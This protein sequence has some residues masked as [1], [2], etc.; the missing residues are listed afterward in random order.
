MAFDQKFLEGVLALEGEPAAKIQKI[1]S[2]YEADVNGLK[3]NRDALKGEKEAALA[4]VA[5]FEKKAPE[6][7]AK[8]G[9]LEKKVKGAGT[10]EAKAYY[11]AQLKALTDK[12]AADLQKLTVE[13]DEA[14]NRYSSLLGLSEF[15]RAIEGDADKNAPLPISAAKR[16]MLRDLTYTR[17]NFG[18]RII[19][20]KEM[21]LS[22][23]NKTVRDF[24]AAYIQTPEGK[25]FV[26][27]ENSGGGAGGASK[28]A[29]P[30]G[31]TYK[32]SDVQSNPTLA[33]EYRE[34]VAKGEDVHIVA[35]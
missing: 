5:E 24:L 1:M 32:H 4:K 6:Y 16:A 28:V 7:E 33:K 12:H 20:G 22:E 14:S 26:D 34:R 17:K 9:E 18:R 13:R 29:G 8:I 23:D 27:E 30:K 11:E 35:G 3:L 21:Y 10:E 31:N 2:E 19:D 15:E 25:F